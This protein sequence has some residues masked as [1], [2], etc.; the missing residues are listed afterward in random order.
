MEAENPKSTAQIMGHPIHPMLVPFPIA[1]LVG[2][3]IGDIL[4]WRLA[5]PFW[6]TASLYLLGA[7]IVTALLAA[8]AGLTDFAGSR[9]L[10]A[11]T[12]AWLHMIGNVV[13][14]LIAIVN[15]I[16]RLG[17]PAAAVIPLGLALSAATGFI[18]I[19]TGWLG[20]ELVFKHRAGVAELK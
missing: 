2:A 14:V 20:G 9:R 4:F 10:R 19:F 12:P 3:L 13:A 15:L 6:A 16:V 1:F 17:D 11:L 18:L 5:D 8:L 7:G